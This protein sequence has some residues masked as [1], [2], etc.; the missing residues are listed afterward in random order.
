MAEDEPE[1]IEVDRDIT[2][3]LYSASYR[4]LAGAPAP[5]MYVTLAFDAVTYSQL[6]AI[7]G[8]NLKGQAVV[9]FANIQ[10]PL[11]DAPPEEKPQAQ[12]PLVMTG[13]GGEAIMAHIFKMDAELDGHCTYCDQGEDNPIH[14]EAHPYVAD[15]REG[16]ANTCFHCAMG[17]E[18]PVHLDEAAKEARERMTH[19]STAAV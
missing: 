14:I 1:V 10:A 7:I 17:E 18:N 11:P 19:R 15:N 3:E 16:K 13:P 4:R 2:A 5:R 9:H 6:C 12:R 8:A